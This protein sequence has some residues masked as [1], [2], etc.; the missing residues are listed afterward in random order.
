MAAYQP[1]F[2]YLA[3]ECIVPT[4]KSVILGQYSSFV[5]R[6]M[7]RD[8]LFSAG[9]EIVSMLKKEP[10]ELIKTIRERLYL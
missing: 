4:V 6:N 5:Y 10:S 3:N 7:E 2:C 9:F 1:D 8:V